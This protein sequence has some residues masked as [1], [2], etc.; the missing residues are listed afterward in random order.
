MGEYYSGW[1]DMEGTTADSLPGFN[2]CQKKNKMCEL[3][4][5]ANPFIYSHFN[6]GCRPQEIFAYF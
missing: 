1:C 3:G 4:G 6:Q 5:Y 2:V